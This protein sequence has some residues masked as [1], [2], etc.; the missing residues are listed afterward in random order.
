MKKQINKRG[1]KTQNK[2][3]MGKMEERK[4]NELQKATEKE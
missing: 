4:R 1:K 3:G 2:V